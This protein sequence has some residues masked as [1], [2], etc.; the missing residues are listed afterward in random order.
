MGD[1]SREALGE[2][3]EDD[4]PLEGMWVSVALPMALGWGRKARRAQKVQ[5]GDAK[6]FSALR[7]T[8]TPCAQELSD[9]K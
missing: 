9:F 5:A 1:T 6:P 4:F 8:S 3:D 7:V 2:E